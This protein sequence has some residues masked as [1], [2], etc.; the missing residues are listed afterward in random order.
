MPLYDWDH[1]KATINIKR[2]IRVRVI[3][4]SLETKRFRTQT[5]A[6]EQIDGFKISIFMLVPSNL[7]P[8]S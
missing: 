4:G 6:M 3:L 7:L 8:F 5:C 1:V 2:P